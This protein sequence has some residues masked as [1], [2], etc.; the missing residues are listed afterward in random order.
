MG[1]GDTKSELLGGGHARQQGCF[2]L[3]VRSGSRAGGVSA[4]AAYAYVTRTDEYS[5]TERDPAVFVES[6][7]MPGWA[8]DA[9]EDY[10]EA[11]DL[12]ERA[13]GRLYVAADFALPRELE[14]DDQIEIAREFAESI[15]EEERLPYTLAIH[16]GRDANG[17][18]HNPHA[19][20]M[21][22]E[23]PNDGI[24]RTREQWFKRAQPS[25][26]ARGGA[27]KT[28]AVHGREW[29]EG[30]RTRWAE[31]VNQKLA[32]RGHSRFVD[33]RSYRRQ[34]LDREPGQHFGPSAAPIVGRGEGHER[35]DDALDIEA[36]N[37][38]IQV[39]DAEISRLAVER[40][41]LLA[42]AIGAE[43]DD[44]PAAERATTSRDDD[45]SWGR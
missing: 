23:R 17:E 19:H 31:L 10:W 18:R 7:H 30:A 8:A 41:A 6:G 21:F 25:A 43:R 9:P 36:S 16:S 11:A 15:T 37:R 44:A 35:L 22:S 27:P 1:L 2:H 45:Q 34:G 4:G 12:F 42:T 13:N 39:L 38:E 28:R 32:T 33:H 26:P 24:D 40:E 3:S 20:L 14:L 5:G 29:M